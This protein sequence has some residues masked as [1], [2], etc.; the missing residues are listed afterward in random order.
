M[1]GKNILTTNKRY[2]TK[3]ING[4]DAVHLGDLGL[5]Y[6]IID[7]QNSVPYID[8]NNA[9]KVL[10][11][12]K[13]M[14]QYGTRYKI[15]SAMGGSH[16]GGP[17]SH[18]AGQKL[19]IAP[20]Q[21]TTFNPQVTS[22][23]NKNYVGNGAIGQEPD[24]F[25]ITIGG[26]NRVDLRPA[27][28]IYNANPQLNQLYN[29]GM[30][31][32]AQMYDEMVRQQAELARQYD[33][34]R[35]RNEAQERINQATQQ[36]V[37][38]IQEQMMTN[39][40]DPMVFQHQQQHSEANKDLARDTARRDLDLAQLEY[41]RQRTPEE[42]ANMYD[43]RIQRFLN[44]MNAQN[45]Y[46]Q[47]QGQVQGYQINPEQYAKAL[48]RDNALSSYMR[49]AAMLN[50]N[51]NPRLAAMQMEAARQGQNTAEQYLKQAQMNYVGQVANRLGL[52]P[53]VVQK[54]MEHNMKMAEA[55]AP[56][57]SSTYKEASVLQPNQ[58]LR[59]Y[60]AEIPK[61]SEK[62]YGDTVA[63]E[64]NRM[65]ELL[66]RN[67]LYSEINKPA[68]NAQVNSLGEIAEMERK[69]PQ[70]VL[71]KYQTQAGNISKPNQ[72]IIQGNTSMTDKIME[73]LQ[74]AYQDINK[75]QM[76]AYQEQGKDIR[77]VMDI[78]QQQQKAQTPSTTNNPLAQAQKKNTFV[79][80]V[81]K[82]YTDP[83]TGEPREGSMDD[84]ALELQ[85]NGFTPDEI[86][87]YVKRYYK[88]QG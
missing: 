24:H 73:D 44:T 17:R 53:E 2:K 38:Q 35:A 52:P 65:N 62:I 83:Y 42:M 6:G 41:Y 64:E 45:P 79:N 69:Y 8:V 30:L 16:Q 71:E 37:P 87:T 11:L 4:V 43:E 84:F 7:S 59:T 39:I 13:A 29:Q 34:A 36:A 15:T 25:D 86:A 10:D 28:G 72:A 66:Q 55:L 78:R 14:G 61:Q 12:D 63:D 32:N 88:G 3:R 70:Q 60:M 74:K 40:D 9:Q 46:N 27:P 21:G 20:I 67:K 23:L 49:G 81:I 48:A 68:A 51:S 57:A 47:V 31:S 19:D 22:F 85:K 18:G 54:Q 50:A 1:D 58:N 77:K 76:A 80:S 75:Q 26:G 33:I 56:G 5:Q 82:G